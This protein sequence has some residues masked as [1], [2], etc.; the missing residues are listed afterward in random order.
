MGRWMRLEPNGPNYW[1]CA[2][3]GREAAESRVPRD[4]QSAA[5]K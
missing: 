5:A 3:R 4:T 1:L 2:H